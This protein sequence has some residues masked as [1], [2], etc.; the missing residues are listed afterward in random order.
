[1]AEIQD[2]YNSILKENGVD[3]RTISRKV[4]KELLRSEID[5]VEFSKPKRVNESERVAVKVH[6]MQQFS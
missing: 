6:E 5:D 2:A 4:L 3:K 1:M